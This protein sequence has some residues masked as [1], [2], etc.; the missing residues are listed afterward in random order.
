MRTLESLSVNVPG[1][2]KMAG[3]DDVKYASLLPVPLTTIRQPCAELGATA[4]RVMVDRVNNPALPA[5]DLLLDF[6]LIVRESSGAPSSVLDRG[7][8]V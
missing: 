2:I 7:V 4:V 8:G 1:D 6:K 5:R 3:F